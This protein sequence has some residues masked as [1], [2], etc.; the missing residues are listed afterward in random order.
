MTNQNSAFGRLCYLNGPNLSKKLLF[1]NLR[2]LTFR[3]MRVSIDQL[4]LAHIG[5]NDI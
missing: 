5:Y 1:D 3:S 4:M 2:Y